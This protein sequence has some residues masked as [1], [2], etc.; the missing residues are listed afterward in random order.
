MDIRISVAKIDK[1][2]IQLRTTAFVRDTC[3]T[4]KKYNVSLYLLIYWR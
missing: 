2:I 3:T 1:K 4:L